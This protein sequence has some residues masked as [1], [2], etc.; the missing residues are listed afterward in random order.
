MLASVDLISDDELADLLVALD[1]VEQEIFDGSFAFAPSDEDIHTAVERRVS[2]LTPAGAKLHTGRSRND[3]SVTGLRLFTR[4]SIDNVS[5][6][7]RALQTTLVDKA[8]SMGTAA[9]PAYTHLQ[10]AQPVSL[11]HHL[12]AY[13]WS[14]QRDIERLADTRHR[15]NVSPLG[16]GA[17]AGSTLPL[18]LEA[19]TNDLG[20]DKTFD[21]SIDAVG[22]RDF[23]AEV[24]FDLALLGVHLGRLAED[25]I[26][27]CTS[28]FGYMKLDDG[29]ATGSSMMPQKK[30]PDAAELARGKTGRLIGNLT[31]LLT[32]LKGLPSGYSKDLQEDK[33]PLFDSVDT[34]TQVIPALAGA[35]ETATFDVARM[36][37]AASDPLLGATD[38]AE[39]LVATGIPFREAHAIVGDLVKRSLDGEDSFESLL[40]SSPS[41]GPAALERLKSRPSRP[42]GHGAGSPEDTERQ[43]D[44]LRTLLGER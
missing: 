26:L 5:E 31:A 8:D 28:E 27:W 10:R 19:T 29:F 38:L 34:I 24:L 4:A 11:A 25:I 22:D 23:V 17:I 41:L 30:N 6:L 16:A 43:I 35:I 12:L 20:F 9:L 32:T 40:A 18:D 36:G 2:D 1:Q 13:A 39:W 15:V 7:V 42:S 44:R 33:E 14:L 37:Q 21:N 3:Q